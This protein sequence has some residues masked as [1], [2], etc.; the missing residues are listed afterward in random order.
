MN[1][2]KPMDFTH[3]G[4]VARLQTQELHALLQQLQVGLVDVDGRST[5]QDGAP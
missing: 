2:M 4:P 5:Y 3:T 1:L